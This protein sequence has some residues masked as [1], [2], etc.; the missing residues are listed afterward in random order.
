[1]RVSEYEVNTALEKLRD[2]IA[3]RNERHGDQPHFSR[4]ESVAICDEEMTEIKL[5]VHAKASDQELADEYLD[6]ACAA[7]WAFLSVDKYQGS[8]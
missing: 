4:H 5:A 2:R 8:K 3:S 6:L 7:L 1:M